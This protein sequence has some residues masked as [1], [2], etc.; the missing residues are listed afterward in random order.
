M[1]IENVLNAKVLRSQNLLVSAELYTDETR[2]HVTIP[3]NTQVVTS[4]SGRKQLSAPNN[5][6]WRWAAG[7]G[8]V[9]VKLNDATVALLRMRDTGAPSF[10]GHLTLGSGISSSY[11]ELFYP[12]ELAVREAFEEFLIA[13]PDGIVL[14]V[15]GN[16]EV[17]RLSFGAVAS[18]LDLIKQKPELLQEFQTGHF[19]R[20]E[21][22]FLES[23]KERT[24]SVQL[25]EGERAESHGVIVLDPGTRGIDL[26]RL[27]EI[28]LPHSIDQVAVF[29]GEDLNGI[30]LDSEVVLF[31]PQT[32]NIVRSYQTGKTIRGSAATDRMTPVTV[33]ALNA[34]SARNTATT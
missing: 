27:I 20:A 16:D 17:D 12:T 28:C 32:R 24:I 26:I 22:R 5:S 10:S 25:E 15:F 13:T 29:D 8:L 9:I 7:G 19:V 18:G 31:D 23:P 14:P 33:E 2:V 3:R 21:A 11:R 30:P 6:R 4:A 1:S 34:L